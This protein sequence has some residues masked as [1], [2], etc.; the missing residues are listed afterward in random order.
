MTKAF[1]KIT[2]FFILLIWLL[3]SCNEENFL[4]D[5]NASLMFSADTVMFDTVFTTIGSTTQS[6][7]V[8]NKYGQPVQVSSI[9]LAGG[10]DS[11]FRLN[12]DGV[13]TND[14]SDVQIRAMD[15]VFIFVEVTVNP[16][17]GSQPMVVEDSIIFTINGNEQVI[18]LMAWGQDF[19]PI[20]SQIIDK[21]TTWSNEKPYLIYNYAYVEEG[22]TLK[23]EHGTKIYFHKDAGLYVRGQ[24]EANGTV[25]EPITFT[26]DRLEEL[27]EDVPSQWY[28]VVLY[29]NKNE[30]VFKNTIIQNGIVGLQV[31]TIEYEGAANVSLE[32]VQIQHMSYAGIFALKSN[33]DATNTVIADCGYYAVTL[34]IGG[35]YDFNHCT[36]ANYWGGYSNRQTHSLYFSNELKVNDTTVFYGNLDKVNWTNSII[37][38]NLT[39]EVGY[40]K[41]EEYLMEYTFDHCLVKIAD[42]VDVT[43]EKHYNAIIKNEDPKFVDYS[44][45]DWQLDTLSVAKDAGAFEFSEFAPLDILG[46]SREKDDGPDLGAYERVEKKE[47]TK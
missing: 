20:N 18:N 13:S 38:G 30:S 26:G 11:D 19:V 23:I 37:W 15:S 47:D 36:V 46:V 21:D 7:R 34:L 12:I 33:I 2:G 29:P 8:I 43:D 6:F 40:H 31:G 45:Y 9:Y 28:G 32:N 10:D 22:V 17:G 25:S 35:E 1:F 41:N 42:S 44:E 3:N 16:N 39:S 27:Y 24:I 4:S 5:D 14:T